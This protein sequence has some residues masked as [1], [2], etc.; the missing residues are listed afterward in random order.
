MDHL[1]GSADHS[2]LLKHELAYCLGRM[3]LVSAF[4]VT[5][6]AL[7]NLGQDLTI[8][9][10]VSFSIA[11]L[12]MAPFLYAAYHNAKWH[13]RPEAEE[14]SG[15][16]SLPDYKAVLATPAPLHLHWEPAAGLLREA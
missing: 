11:P 2:T 5:Q 14:T 13:S 10:E 9:H 1:S 6:S 8:R 16:I 4:P 12:R 15:P 3:K 7:E